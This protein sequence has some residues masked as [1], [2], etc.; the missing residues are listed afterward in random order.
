M[1]L[2]SILRGKTNLIEFGE[3]QK[4]LRNVSMYFTEPVD[5]VLE[6]NEN[7]LT[8]VFLSSIDVN[9][10]PARNE[11]NIVAGLD[12]NA[13]YELHAS[14]FANL[15]NYGRIETDNF[16]IQSNIYSSYY[17]MLSS[18]PSTDHY[19]SLNQFYGLS[20]GSLS[21]GSLYNDYQGH[22]FWDTGDKIKEKKK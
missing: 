4:E 3:F 10:A 18:L 6:A 14:K 2:L 13:I 7:M 19:G 20:P 16:E 1:H 21:R 15:W 9:E 22:S 12:P 8:R 5:L 17:Y 11:F